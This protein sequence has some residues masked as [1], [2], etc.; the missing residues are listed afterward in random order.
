[1]E[2]LGCRF[3]PWGSA[4]SLISFCICFTIKL[5][6]SLAILKTWIILARS[7]QKQYQRKGSTYILVQTS[8]ENQKEIS[9]SARL[10]STSLSFC[11]IVIGFLLKQLEAFLPFLL[12]WIDCVYFTGVHSQQGHNWYEM[13]TRCKPSVKYFVVSYIGRDWTGNC[14]LHGIPKLSTFRDR[15]IGL[16]YEFTDWSHMINTIFLWN[17]FKKHWNMNASAKAGI[18]VINWTWFKWNQHFAPLLCF[19]R[20]ASDFKRKSFL[21]A[22]S[23]K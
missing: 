2:T 19:K 10:L 23:S 18:V 22:P 7:A 8:V 9:V 16:T 13:K 1:M 17:I 21:P 15:L 3:S 6:S 12:C 14:V 20:T 5:K 11:K 4:A